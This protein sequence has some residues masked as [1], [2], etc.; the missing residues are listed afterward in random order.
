MRVAASPTKF[1]GTCL[2]TFPCETESPADL[3]GSAQRRAAHQGGD[4]RPPTA[5]ETSPAPV[6]DLATRVRRR[7]ILNGLINEYTQAA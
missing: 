4:Q 3:C 2:A 6:T 5:S 7:K 1:P